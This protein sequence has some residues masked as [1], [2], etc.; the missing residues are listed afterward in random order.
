MIKAIILFIQII[1]ANILFY[2]AVTDG[3]EWTINITYFYTV[4]TL[5][6]IIFTEAKPAI[7][8]KRLELYRNGYAGKIPLWFDYLVFIYRMFLFA[9]FG[10]WWTVTAWVII[11]SLDILHRKEADKPAKIILDEQRVIKQAYDYLVKPESQKP[12]YHTTVAELRQVIEQ[13]K[14]KKK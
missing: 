13:N 2:F 7:K 10:W 3:A 9:A 1:L 6:Q 4:M 14:P 8:E 5:I 11:S 12:D